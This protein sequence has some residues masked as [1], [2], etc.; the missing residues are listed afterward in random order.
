MGRPTIEEQP[1]VAH[2]A[3]DPIGVAVGAVVEVA[4]PNDAPLDFV[5]DCRL[6]GDPKKTRKRTVIREDLRFLYFWS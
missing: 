4:E 5:Q 6:K 3:H 2:S 1:T